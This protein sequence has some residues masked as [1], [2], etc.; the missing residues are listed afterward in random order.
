MYGDDKDLI[1]AAKVEHQREMEAILG[2]NAAMPKRPKYSAG[3]H[4][5]RWL[6]WITSARISNLW[7]PYL[8]SA[9][10]LNHPY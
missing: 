9:N 1:E 4:K 7:D 3:Y 5:V 10:S 8:L 2:D 6:A